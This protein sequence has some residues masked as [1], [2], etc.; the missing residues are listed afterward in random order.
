MR[1]RPAR[2]AGHA[3]GNRRLPWPF[4]T[5]DGTDAVPVVGSGGR[6]PK[7]PPE[8]ASPVVVVLVVGGDNLRPRLSG[9]AGAS[10]LPRRTS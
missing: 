5:H 7:E 2:H 4:F 10:S 9:D 3:V 1:S 8:F 6:K